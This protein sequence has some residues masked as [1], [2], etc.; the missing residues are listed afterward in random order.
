MSL[1]FK[2]LS[3]IILPLL[4]HF[5]SQESAQCEFT[6]HRAMGLMQHHDA[7]TGTEKQNVAEDYSYR[8]DQ[9]NMKNM[10]IQLIIAC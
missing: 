9:V 10:A 7:V 4:I 1:F 5:S 2:Q 6:L 8:L 3:H